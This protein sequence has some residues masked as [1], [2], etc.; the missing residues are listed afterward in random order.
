LPDVKGEDDLEL[1]LIMCPA[2]D[3]KYAFRATSA[4]PVAADVHNAGVRAFMSDYICIAFNLIE[5]VFQNCI[6]PGEVIFIE[7][8]TFI[9]DI[10]W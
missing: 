2:S 4:E 1:N 10:K 9:L 3:Q 6:Q 5:N 7:E 8:Y